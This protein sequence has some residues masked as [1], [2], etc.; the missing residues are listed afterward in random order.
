MDSKHA[1][2]K[3]RRVSSVLA[4]MTG[5]TQYQILIEALESYVDS[6]MNERD[7]EIIR[8]MLKT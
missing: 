8:K 4:K 2:S 5:K 1:W 7:R 6:N 3:I